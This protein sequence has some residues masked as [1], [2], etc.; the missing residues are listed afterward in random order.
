MMDERT[1]HTARISAEAVSEIDFL[2]RRPEFQRFMLKLEE[3]RKRYAEAILG[4]ESL[5]AEEREK[6]RQRHVELSDVLEWPERERQAHVSILAS[7]GIQPGDGLEV[8]M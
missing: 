5:S 8:G 4:D 7:F 1:K 2:T 3:R 6:L